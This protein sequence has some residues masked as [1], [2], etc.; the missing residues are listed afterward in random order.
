MEVPIS[1]L[2]FIET[3]LLLTLLALTGGCASPARYTHELSG[4]LD[5]FV[6]FH[7]AAAERCTLHLGSD[8]VDF[9]F[10]GHEGHGCLLEFPGG[11]LWVGWN[12]RT[13]VATVDVS[14]DYREGDRLVE[15]YRG[16][17]AV[18]PG[19][20]S[21]LTGTATE[22]TS[23][24]AL[25]VDLTIHPSISIVGSSRFEVSGDTAR[26]SG[27]LGVGTYAQ[28]VSLLETHPELRRITFEDVPGSL[29][30]D[31]NRETGRL[32]RRAG[33]ET[34]LPAH[35]VAASGGVD[36]FLAGDRR[37]V[38]PGARLG[39]HSWCCAYGVPANEL[40]PDHP[41]HL[42]AI[43]YLEEMLGESGRDFYFFAIHAA[44]SDSIHW[45]TDE[46]IRTWSLST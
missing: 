38:E 18:E 39:V 42:P 26:L 25:P 6:A 9:A 41:R 23:G 37:V 21:R 4:D 29:H 46:E 17:L 11:S 22:V 33:L 1:R 32:L 7:V 43:R 30:D 40:P 36:L 15:N 24:R 35:G 14:I 44:E 27:R 20:P 3:F 31:V 12:E 16:R 2:G 13:T 45:L 10:A 19:T 28:L 34:H 5:R 8:R